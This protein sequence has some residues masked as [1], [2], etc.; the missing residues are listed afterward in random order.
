MRALLAVAAPSCVAGCTVTATTATPPAYPASNLEWNVDRPGADYRSFELPAP[1]PDQ[2]QSSC[3]NEPQCV[4]FTYVN[5][6]M[7]GPNAR[8]WLKNVVPAVFN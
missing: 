1:S 7:Q 6:G 8:C 4:A 5:P 2:C 3:M